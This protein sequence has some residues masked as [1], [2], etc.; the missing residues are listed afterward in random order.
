M[1]SKARTP[2]TLPALLPPTTTMSP[3]ITRD[4]IS[5]WKRYF[6]GRVVISSAFGMGRGEVFYGPT[7]WLGSC[8]PMTH[9]DYAPDSYS[10]LMT[11]D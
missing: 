9:H 3:A 7:D 5:T 1:S 10:G 6:E 4:Q 11:D 2:L 8:D